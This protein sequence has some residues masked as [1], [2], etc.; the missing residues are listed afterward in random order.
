MQTVPEVLL[1][2]AKSYEIIDG[3]PM[4]YLAAGVKQVD[5]FA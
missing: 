5:R 2:P 3:R 4:G 1:D